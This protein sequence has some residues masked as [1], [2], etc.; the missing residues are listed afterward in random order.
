MTSCCH[1]GLGLQILSSLELRWVEY[2]VTATISATY[3]YARGHDVSTMYIIAI[4]NSATM[5]AP[6]C[7]LKMLK[8]RGG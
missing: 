1:V 3:I 7:T 5:H 2:Y 6:Q 4:T 8:S